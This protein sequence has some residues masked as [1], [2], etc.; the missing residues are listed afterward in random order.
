MTTKSKASTDRTGILAYGAYVP[1]RRLQRSAIH[2]ANSWYAPG[3]SRA[4]KGEKAIGN[5][6]EDVIT[7]AVEAGRDCLLGMDRAQL[8]AIRLA[9]TTL[10]N[11]DRLN[12]GI[13]KEALNLSNQL[14]ASDNSGSQRAATTSL[15][16]A[17]DSDQTSLVLSSE[18]RIA[19]AASPSEMEFGEAAA[20]LVVGQGEPIAVPVA[21]ASVTVDFIDHFRETGEEFDYVWESRWVRDEGYIKILGAAIADALRSNSIDPSTITHSAI[22]VAERSV[23]PKLLKGARINPDSVVDNQVATIGSTGT[24]YPFMLLVAALERA[25]PGDRILLA[26]FGQGA[27]VFVFEVTDAITSFTP[28]MGVS[29]WLSER[30][31]DKNYQRYLFH[32]GLLKTETGMRAEGDQKQPGTTLFRERKSVM[33]LVGGKCTKTGTVQ[34]P[35]TDISVS[36][37][38]RTQGTQEDYPMAEIP[39]NI[40]TYTADNLTFSPDPP[41]YYGNVDFEGGGRLTA[42]FTDVEADDVEVGREM[43]MVFRVKARDEQRGFTKYFWKA[44]P[45]PQ[46][47]SGGD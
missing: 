13:V 17:L 28:R 41:T 26:S 15:M 23:A 20:G 44:A 10:P 36:P 14:Q 31:E 16:Q 40:V 11:A 1:R 32:R 8:D 34:F 27:D 25:K 24:T 45:R 6:D 37:N 35:K 3:L 30:N 47:L 19:R 4:A 39:V 2:A 18:K 38:D 9:S 5:W 29:G 43:R 12:A 22:A 7:M 42:E 33:A 46:A 21:Q